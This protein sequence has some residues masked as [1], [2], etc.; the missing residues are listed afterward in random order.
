MIDESKRQRIIGKFEELPPAIRTE[1]ASESDLR[2][3]ENQFGPIRAD[4]R[5]F[6][7]NCGGGAVGAEWLDGIEELSQTHQKFQS[8]SETENGWTMEDVFVIGWD[9]AGNPF[10]IEESTGRILIE[11][12]NFGGIHE[13]AQSLEEFL[14]DCL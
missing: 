1:P 12:H 11:D 6:L 10:G 13:M 7:L 4:Y 14:S 5:W 3:F 9:G 8:E 2:V